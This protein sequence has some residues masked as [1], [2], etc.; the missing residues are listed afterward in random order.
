MSFAFPRRACLGLATVCAV[1]AGI[2]ISAPAAL[3]DSCPNN[4]GGSGCDVFAFGTS[5]E[6]AM[7][8]SS[9]QNNG[10]LT[11]SQD[12]P[13]AIAC[14]GV[15]LAEDGDTWAF[16]SNSPIRWLTI[17]EYFFDSSGTG[18]FCYASIVPFVVKLGTLP[19]LEFVNGQLQYVGAL[20]NCIFGR[21]VPPCIQFSSPDQITA[22]VLI[23][24]HGRG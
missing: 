18:N 2:A 14:P 22:V 19:R 3:A 21:I 4:E 11:I 17:N 9:N 12:A 6:T 16:T 8:V 5:G 23:D 13:F 15:P 10:T 20:P 7:D 1:T 24:A